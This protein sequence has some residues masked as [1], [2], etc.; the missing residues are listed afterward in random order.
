MKEEIEKPKHWLQTDRITI[1]RHKNTS[2]SLSVS[3]SI[4]LFEFDFAHM[5]LLLLLY[6]EQNISR[7][8]KKLEHILLLFLG[9]SLQFRD[10]S[11][12]RKERFSLSYPL[13]NGLD[14]VHTEASHSRRSSVFSFFPLNAEEVP[15]RWQVNTTYFNEWG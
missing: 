14:A 9:S 2:R 3:A 4:L 5:R 11:P 1:I 10:M 15:R 7:K 6:T 12:V 8:H 13:Q